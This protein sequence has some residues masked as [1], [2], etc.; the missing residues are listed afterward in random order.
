MT[1]RA[2]V[3]IE[4]PAQSRTSSAEFYNKVFGWEFQHLT[5]PGPYSMA[6]TGNVGVGLP[7]V[8]DDYKVGDVIIYLDSDDIAADL[9][10]IEDAGG[11]RL[12]EPM[13][14]GEMGEMVFFADP[15]GNRL[16]LWKT[17]SNGG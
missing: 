6:E 4:I 16:A 2:F 10:K 3:H 12:S 11:K 8:S 15:A 17:F 7:D 9:K 1:K 14:I 5:E 13:K